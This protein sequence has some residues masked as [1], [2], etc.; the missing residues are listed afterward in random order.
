MVLGQLDD[1]SLGIFILLFDFCNGSW[2]NRRTRLVIGTSRVRGSTRL[3]LCSRSR[4]LVIRWDGLTTGYVD[5]DDIRSETL[6][7][8]RVL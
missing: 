8:L 7:V 4:W 6:D 5:M 1:K 3:G 2:L